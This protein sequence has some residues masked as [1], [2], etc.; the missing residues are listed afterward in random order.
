ME[1]EHLQPDFSC[2]AERAETGTTVALTCVILLQGLRENP[3]VSVSLDIY[4]RDAICIYG[5]HGDVCLLT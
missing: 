3:K 5:V 2:S 4:R 1:S